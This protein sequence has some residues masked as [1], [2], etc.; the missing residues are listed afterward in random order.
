MA[1][2]AAKE[3]AKHKLKKMLGPYLSEPADLQKIYEVVD[4]IK[5]VDAVTKG[6]QALT[7]AGDPREFL[8]NLRAELPAL[9]PALLYVARAWLAS[10]LA[11]KLEASEFGPLVDELLFTGGHVEDASAATLT[12][13]ITRA[14]ARYERLELLWADLKKLADPDACKQFIRELFEGLRGNAPQPPATATRGG[15]Q[16][17]CPPDESTELAQLSALS[18]AAAPSAAANRTASGGMGLKL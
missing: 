14:M 3:R 13:D 10:K 12:K 4:Q 11:G 18:A 16:A 7:G 15:M 2:D 8:E 1:L 5:S 17:E 9:E 6:A